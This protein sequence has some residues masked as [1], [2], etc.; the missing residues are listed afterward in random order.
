MR[1][2]NG[3]LVETIPS[4]AIANV[5]VAPRPLNIIYS[6]YPKVE[7]KGVS[8]SLTVSLWDEAL[9]EIADPAIDLSE[10]HLLECSL[11]LTGGSGAV[12]EGSNQASIDSGTG[13]AIFTGLSIVEPS[14][15]YKIEVVCGDWTL[16]G[17]EFAVH[18]WPEMATV[19]KQ[20]IGLRYTGSLQH[21]AET[22]NALNHVIVEDQ[23]DISITDVDTGEP[24]EDMYLDLSKYKQKQDPTC[25]PGI[26]CYL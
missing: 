24:P 3:D 1:N 26:T 12:L 18:D 25:Y 16:K 10:Y 19:R 22:L 23:D 14:L 17:P 13:Q 5:T 7:P 2:S 11:N 6:E 8:F 21:A 20:T 4:L 9:N 15:D